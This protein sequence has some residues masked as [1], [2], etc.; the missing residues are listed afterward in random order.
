MKCRAGSGGNEMV[1]DYAA[2]SGINASKDV[3]MHAAK[4]VIVDD[5]H[6]HAEWTNFNKG[7][8]D[9]VMVFDMTRRK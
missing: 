9:H 2:S 8:Q 1:F 5:D 6:L 4:L 7:K 3:H